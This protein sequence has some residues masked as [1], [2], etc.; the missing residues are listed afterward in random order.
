MENG[1]VD[2]RYSTIASSQSRTPLLFFLVLRAFAFAVHSVVL[3][4]VTR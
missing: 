4:M 3:G 1:K 2:V